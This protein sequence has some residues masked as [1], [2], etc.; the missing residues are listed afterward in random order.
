[1]TRRL[2]VFLLALAALLGEGRALADK[3]CDAAY[4]QAQRLRDAKKLVAAREQL[5]LCARSTCAPSVS[6]DC[7]T[8]L[9]EVEAALPT[10]VV[11]ADDK[12]GSPLASASVSIDGGP[13]RPVTGT[14]WE[15]DPGPHTFSFRATGKV[16]ADKQVL[17]VQGQKDQR[18]AVTLT[19]ATASVVAPPPPIAVVAAPPPEN[20]ASGSVLKPV[21][22]AVGGVGVAGIIV[23]AIFG[24]VAL[25]TKSSDCRTETT[26]TP[27]SAS[28]AL[29]QGNISTIGFVAG[30]VL[31][32]GGL[33]MVLLAPKKRDTGAAT[34]QA[35]PLVGE[36]A[37]GVMVSGGWW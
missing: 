11:V 1:M 22:Y 16:A 21:G 18:V 24:G 4:D 37:G 6:K 20:A 27:G 8:W 25:S 15:V 26:C 10:V 36:A 2:P 28:K 34:V 31:A 9:A 30:G 14:S 35:S 12:A 33:T 7:V 13:P 19:D 17:V 32:A 5:R 3:T 29:T 23:G